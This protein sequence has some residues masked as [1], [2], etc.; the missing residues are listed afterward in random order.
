[1]LDWNVVITV[2]DDNFTRA[3]QLLSRFGK[4]KR[5]DFYNV[6]VMKVED[7]AEFR[8]QFA[9]H[10]AASDQKKMAFV[11]SRLGSITLNE[12]GG[13]YAYRSSKASLLHPESAGLLFGWLPWLGAMVRALRSIIHDNAKPNEARDMLEELKNSGEGR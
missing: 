11:T 13:R 5:T 1:M 10:V 12:E 4:V 8:E 6:L 3:R 9:D 2:H 7:V